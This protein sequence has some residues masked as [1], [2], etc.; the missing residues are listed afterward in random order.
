MQ[1]AVN[2][3]GEILSAKGKYRTQYNALYSNRS[4][5]LD[6]HLAREHTKN[7][8]MEL[9]K[10]REFTGYYK[11]N[12]NYYGMKNSTT[13]YVTQIYR[14]D[15]LTFQGLGAQNEESYFKFPNWSQKKWNNIKTNFDVDNT[16]I[17]Q[18]DSKFGTTLFS[19]KA[20][21]AAKRV[22][23]KLDKVGTRSA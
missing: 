13:N 21:N 1:K 15:A 18:V 9:I 4:I 7:Y 3:V 11:D 2:P 16:P 12:P 17:D 22:F 8:L 5:D 23:K 14:L 19:S 6:A 20:K 10:R